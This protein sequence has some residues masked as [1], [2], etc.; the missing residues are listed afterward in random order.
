M[1]EIKMN[2]V[3]FYNDK[4]KGVVRVLVTMVNKEKGVMSFRDIVTMKKKNS[5][6][7]AFLN[8]VQQMD[9]TVITDKCY[10][11][12]EVLKHVELLPAFAKEVKKYSI[13]Q[14]KHVKFDGDRIRVSSDRL[15]LFNEKGVQCVH[16]S[17]KGEYFRKTTSNS[18][19]TVF[20]FNL[21]G[22]DS[23]GREVL[24]NKDH[25]IPKS[26]GGRDVFNNF[27]T[28]CAPCNSRKGNKDEE[29]MLKKINS[30]KNRG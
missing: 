9:K 11:V 30:S 12:E 3:Y 29:E 7:E 20:H 2:E 28:M 17:T 19:Y 1:E 15:S 18:S 23:K 13:K 21:Y 14:N 16:C 10:S 5:H 25:I 8:R 4:K 6:I 26:K 22:T 24:M 27:Q